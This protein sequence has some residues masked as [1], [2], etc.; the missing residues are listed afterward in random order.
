MR[1]SIAGTEQLEVPCDMS[2]SC[3][4]KFSAEDRRQVRKTAVA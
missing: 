1:S 3:S 2:T 4:M